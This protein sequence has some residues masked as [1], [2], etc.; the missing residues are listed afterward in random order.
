MR[1]SNCKARRKEVDTDRI[2]F[3]RR[4]IKYGYC[5]DCRS[6]TENADDVEVKVYKK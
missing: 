2:P 6:R 3:Y 4:N 5:K 1:T